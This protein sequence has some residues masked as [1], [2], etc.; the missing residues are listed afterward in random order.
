MIV[1]LTK[2]E[3]DYIRELIAEEAEY[4]L[5]RDRD[6]TGVINILLA[7]NIAEDEEQD[8]L[9]D[10]LETRHKNLFKGET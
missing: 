3:I 1:R 6:A 5:F 7:L 2:E 9:A 10:Y 4:A 8:I